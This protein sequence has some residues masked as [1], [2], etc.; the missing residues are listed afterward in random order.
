MHFYYLDLYEK[1]KKSTVG[2]N[3]LVQHCFGTIK[4]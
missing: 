2:G 3:L 4:Q 1:N